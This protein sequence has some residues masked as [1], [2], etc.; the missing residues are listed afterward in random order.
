MIGLEL[1]RPWML[2]ALVVAVPLLLY[3][4]VHSLSDFPR[5]Q[6]IVSLAIR[7]CIVLL[8][9]L[10][11][12]GLTL[13]HST[14]EKFVIF[15]VDQ[16]TSV[17]DNAAKTASEFL[18]TA[19][20]NAGSNQVAYLPFAASSAP[21]QTTAVEFGEHASVLGPQLAKK[22]EAKAQ[23]AKHDQPAA[24]NGDSP[25]PPIDQKPTDDIR[26]GTNLAAAVE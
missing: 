25:P 6:R 9:V 8:L 23:E 2:L 20:E 10:A 12:A 11:L 5:R 19:S 24:S 14:S 16:S 1:T 4:F 13:L 18:K 21:V 3:Y 15:V 17:G 7:T 26:D 22:D